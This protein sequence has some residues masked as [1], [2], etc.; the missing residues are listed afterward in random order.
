MLRLL[1]ITSCNRDGASAVEFA[2]IFPVVMALMF[3]SFEMGYY[4]WN[5]HVVVQSVREG[6]RF[7]ARLPFS[8][9]DCATGEIVINKNDPGDPTAVDTA[10]IEKIKLLTRTGQIASTD[11]PPR[12]KNWTSNVSVVVSCPETPVSEGLYDNMENAPIVT[13]SA[14]DVPYPSLFATLGFDTV[15][16][17]LN[18]SSRSAVM[19]L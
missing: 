12:V 14:S 3:S 7:A 16:V 17:K 10:T 8:K 18:A 5:Q 4:F 13:V 2:L 6:A 15:E 19:G 1:K 9:F 11:A